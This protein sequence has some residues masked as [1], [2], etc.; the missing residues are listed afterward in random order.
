MLLTLLPC[1]VWRHS[2]LSAALLTISGTVCAE[3][4]PCQ[5]SGPQVGLVIA[6]NFPSNPTES[7][8][9]A[10]LSDKYFGAV[11][12]L[13]SYWEEVSYGRMTLSGDTLGWFTLDYP[14][15]EVCESYAIR[16]AALERA[17]AYVDL[18]RYNR[19]LI[20]VMGHSGCDNL[21]LGTGSQCTAVSLPNGGTIEASTNWN[22]TDST[23]VIIHEGGHNLGLAHANA[24]DQGATNSVGAIGDRGTSNEYGDIFDVMGQSGRRGHHNALYKYRLG[25]LNDTH[26]LTPVSSSTHT[27]E[28]LTTPGSL[29]AIK[30]FRG[31]YMD[32][33]V[34]PKLVRK[35][36]F[37]VETRKNTGFDTN[38]YYA[39]ETTQ[40]AYGGALVHMDRSWDDNSQLLDMTPGSISN[41]F[42]D[43]PLTVG[44]SFTDPYTGITIKHDNI[45]NTGDIKVSVIIPNPDTD[46]DGIS[47]SQETAGGTNPLVEDTDGDTLSDY[48][49]RCYDMD[50][51]T[52]NPGATDTDA[53][54]SDTDNDGM[55]DNWEI[56]NSLNPLLADGG[57]DTD[58][59]ELTNLREYQQGT[60]PNVADTDADKLSDGEEVDVYG[61]NPLDGT[62]T[63]QDGMRDDW[64]TVRGTDKLIGDANLDADSD[65]VANVIEYLRG[66]LPFDGTSTPVTRTI[67][68]DAGSTG[69]DGSAENPY[70]SL[71]TAISNARHGDTLQ[72]ATGSY[73]TIFSNQKSIS[74][75]GPAD[76]SAVFKAGVFF[77]S[78]ALW[79]EF[80]NINLKLTGTNS[81]SNL[82]NVSLRNCTVNAAKGL[83]V[84]NSHI[85]IMNTVLFGIG[86]ATSSNTGL[87]FQGTNSVVIT[88]ATLVDYRVGVLRYSGTTDLRLTNSILANADDLSGVID[89]AGIAYNLIA[90][91]ELA[92]SRGNFSAAPMFVDAE[93]Y[94][95]LSTSPTI[96]AGDPLADYGNEP[97]NNGKRIN[98]GAYGNTS[99]AAV[100][101][102]SDADG[103]TDQNEW[104]YDGSCGSYQPYNPAIPSA[105]G[106]LNINMADTDA[107]GY[108][109]TEELGAGSS[110]V[111]PGSIPDPASPPSSVPADGDLNLDG[112]INAADM[113]LVQRHVLGIALLTPDQIAHGDL[114]PPVSGDGVINVQDLLL[115]MRAALAP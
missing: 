109:D 88:N 60:N 78:G 16:K 65:G 104:C 96:D 33:T 47:D 42:L 7:L 102:D 44:K 63:D 70:A 112:R 23:G 11:D 87:T 57:V 101:S 73:Y 94:H 59:D 90:D 103:L 61:T 20:R 30:I 93:T 95:T 9:I 100:G 14:G 3:A 68:V 36:Y 75:R 46:E 38:I 72:L 82:R 39:G 6:V 22:Y 81:F 83:L 114:Y 76:R 41:D 80:S 29:K 34:T 53:T 91:G 32:S 107:D 106:D 5:P 86:S 12:S 25:F 15:W 58:L 113:L 97:E 71:T 19:I 13:R 84:S 51:T 1:R 77:H 55:P 92:G 31:A 49:E 18:T 62:D 54:K 99:E 98:L 43:A 17:S 28:P 67:Y 85:N 110:P 115:V 45:F 40:P 105:G 2:L 37:W 89:T 10:E 56:T 69:G 27:I 24:E 50:C 74:M 8:P 111:D 26:L 64:E 4:P 21:I 52:Y 79:G 48:Y 35:E 66:T 108:T